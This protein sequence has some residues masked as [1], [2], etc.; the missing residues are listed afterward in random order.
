LR[1]FHQSGRSPVYSVNGMAATSMPIAS[2]TAIEILRAG[3]NAVD[4][5][6]AACAVLAV[7]EPQSTGL[8]GDC[9]C[10]YAPAGGGKVVAV[11]GSGRSAAAASLD[12][13]KVAGPTPPDDISPH[14][15]TIPGAV[16]GWQLLLDAY[17]TK[18]FDEL[19]LPAIRCAEEGFPVH[20]RVAWDWSMHESK[21]RRAGTKLFLPHGRAPRE[22]DRFVQTA[23]AATLRAIA[24]RGADAFYN[25]PV[26]AD[27][28]ATLRARGGV[29][30]EEDFANGLRGGEFVEPI[31]LRWRG[32][33]VWQCPPNGPGLV[34]LMILG[35]LEALG[36]APDGPAGVTRFHRHI[37]A[38]RMAYRDR[39]AFL[40][41]PRQRETALN[42]LLSPDYLAGLAKHIDDRRS[43]PSLPAPGEIALAASG[44]TVTVSVVDRDGGA[45]SLI[46]SIYQTFGSS[47]LAES[48]GVL[49]QNRGLCFAFE[50]GHPNSFA[51]NTRPAHTI[52]PGL[53]TR[54]GKPAI[55]FGVMG[56]HYQ[57]MGQTWVLTNAVEYGMDIQAAIDFPRVC[58]HLGEVE[59]ERGVSSA[60][61]EKLAALG[62]V[63]TELERPLGGGQAIMID[64]E[65]GVLIGG[66]DPRKDGAA[67]GY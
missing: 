17:G 36:D 8:G 5:A 48:S 6:V 19:L 56:E 16:S 53:A 9:F 64:H 24:K 34:S 42:R 40:A 35:E 43:L 60:M 13:I 12:A 28:A 25:G 4:A 38:A 61:R 66:S 10:L 50:P 55:C 22:G 26:A 33:D 41:D 63:L 59:I 52:M 18:G 67:L 31:S 7:V 3:G 37:E 49:M 62:H 58:P 20:Q 29:Q 23:L 57:P 54:D 14:G 11:N 15:V 27:M 39:G 2:L 65:R 30:T 21:L 45:C 46:N 32:L 44:N 51:P 1:D 47:I